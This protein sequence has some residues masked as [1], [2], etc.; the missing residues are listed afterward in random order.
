MKNQALSGSSDQNLRCVD[1]RADVVLGDQCYEVIVQH[2]TTKEHEQHVLWWL[3]DTLNSELVY[4]ARFRTSGA[5]ARNFW[6]VFSVVNENELL[7]I[8]IFA[9]FLKPLKHIP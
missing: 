7:A 6:S 3:S 8:R 4:G 9:N 5:F 1:A 2:P